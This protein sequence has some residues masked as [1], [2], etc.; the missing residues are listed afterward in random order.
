MRLFID[1][2]MSPKLVEPLFELGHYAEHPRNMG[3]LRA[4]DHQVLGRCLDCDLTI[5]THNAQDFRKLVG[6]TELHPG[7]IILEEAEFD[8]TLQLIK[9]VLAHIQKV[10]GRA[11]PDGYMVNRVIEITIARKIKDYLLPPA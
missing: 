4:L 3:T 5:V 2:C 6:R 11:G 10:S 1:E 9:A 8:V 7:L